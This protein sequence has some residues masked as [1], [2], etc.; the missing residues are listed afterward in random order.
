[1]PN[2]TTAI[3]IFHLCFSV[4]LHLSH[5]LIFILLV[6]FHPFVNVF[7]S[8][9]IYFASSSQPPFF[10]F[11]SIRL[12]FNFLLFPIPCILQLI[13]SSFLFFQFFSFHFHNS[14]FPCFN[15]FGLFFLTF[16]LAHVHSFLSLHHILMHFVLPLCKKYLPDICITVHLVTSDDQSRFEHR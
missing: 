4:T 13:F 14:F 5:L 3:I 11:H 1:M 2:F 9:I 6:Y 10:L 16:L 8:P 7:L 15:S 12:Y